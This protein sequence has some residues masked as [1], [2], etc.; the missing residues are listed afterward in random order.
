MP[1]ILPIICLA[2]VTFT[3]INIG[4]YYAYIELAATADG[5]SSD[6]MGPILTWS[7]IFAIAG[8]V[9]ALFF[10]RFGLFKPLFISLI[11]MAVVVIMLSSGITDLNVMIS[12]FAFNDFMDICRCLSISNDGPYG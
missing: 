1:K 11:A 3:Y 5:I 2:A 9:L 12:L 6:W 8:C 10:S 4:G 7:S